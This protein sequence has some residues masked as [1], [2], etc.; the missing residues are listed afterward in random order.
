MIPNMI[1]GFGEG[2][3]KEF[4]AQKLAVIPFVVDICE[5]N[6]IPKYVSELSAVS[7]FINM[8]YFLWQYYTI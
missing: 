1:L 5:N 7:L 6:I 8:F 3:L 4:P 2:C